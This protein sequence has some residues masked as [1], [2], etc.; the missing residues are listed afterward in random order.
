MAPNEKPDDDDGQAAEWH[1]VIS[2]LVTGSKDDEGETITLVYRIT[3]D[4]AVYITHNGVKHLSRRPLAGRFASI[5]E[6]ASD[7]NHYRGQF[8]FVDIAV[9]QAKASCLEGGTKEAQEVLVHAHQ[10]VLQLL[11]GAGRLRYVLVCMLSSA[12]VVTVVSI[13]SHI[14][15]PQEHVFMAWMVGC[16]SVGAF[17]SVS[18]NLKSLEIDPVAPRLMTTVSAVSR[19]VIGMIGAV[20]VLLVIKGN[21]VL[22]LLADLNNPQALLAIGILAGFSETFVPNVLRR[23]ETQADVAADKTPSNKPLQPTSDA[24]A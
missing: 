15:L 4:F 9:A 19:I 16:G 21:L 18:L 1:S 3:D 11:T 13:L 12:F 8:P 17:L 2:R 6:T 22:G 14:A 7:L 24:K 20:F 10:R 5:T 23:V